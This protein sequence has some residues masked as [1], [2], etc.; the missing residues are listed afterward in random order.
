MKQ[1]KES[2]IKKSNIT[3][4]Y[5]IEPVKPGCNLKDGDL[6][7]I[8]YY[9]ISKKKYSD[10]QFGRYN[11][12]SGDIEFFSSYCH[13]SDLRE[14]FYQHVPGNMYTKY[15]VRV[16]REVTGNPEIE[17]S[18]DDEKT[19]KEIQSNKNYVCIYNDKELSK[20]FRLK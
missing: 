17:V 19:L 18:E 3:N 5:A 15:I 4:T 12:I 7:L 13:Y 8:G 6:V 16:Y 20:K 2:L 11:E 14:T 10:Y 9:L 1:L